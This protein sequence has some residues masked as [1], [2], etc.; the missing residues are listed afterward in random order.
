MPSEK[1]A[2]AANQVPGR[3]RCIAAANRAAAPNTDGVD[4]RK[5]RVRQIQ[6]LALEKLRVILKLDSILQ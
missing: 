2:H 5:E 3:R 1:T 4:L 6:G